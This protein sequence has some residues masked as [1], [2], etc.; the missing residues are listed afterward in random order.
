MNELH[1]PDVISR[2]RAGAWVAVGVVARWLTSGGR[3]AVGRLSV[4]E[5]RRPPRSPRPELINNTGNY[6]A[7]STEIERSHLHRGC[8]VEEEVKPL[9]R[10]GKGREGKGS[11]VPAGGW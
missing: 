10:E 9:R 6:V 11:E 3:A 5:P 1:P 7:Y 2:A 8:S 4:T